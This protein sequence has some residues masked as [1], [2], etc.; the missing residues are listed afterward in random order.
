MKSKQPNGAISELALLH[1]SVVVFSLDT[2]REFTH[3]ITLCANAPVNDWLGITFRTS[4]TRMR[5][6]DGH[7]C[8]SNGA[9][10]TIA[11]DDQRREFFQLR[12]ENEETSFTYPSLGYTISEGDLMQSIC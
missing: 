1:H 3:A 4:K 12:R 8:F 2:N 9:R 10:L 7:P 5:F 11:T 6:L